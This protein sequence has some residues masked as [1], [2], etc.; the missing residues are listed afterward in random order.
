MSV[1]SNAEEQISVKQKS[2]DSTS[3]DLTSPALKPLNSTP[4]TAQFETISCAHP[5]KKPTLNTWWMWRT[6]TQVELK[7]ENAQNSEF[8]TWENGSVNYRFLMHAEKKV[9]EYSPVDLK[10]LNIAADSS[11][12][13]KVSNLVLQ[14]DLASM[15]K[16]ALKKTYNGLALNR[17]D[18][19]IEGV[20][21]DIIWIEQLQIPLQMTYSYPKHKTTINLLDANATSATKSATSEQMLNSYER[22]D[23]ADIGDMEHSASAKKW[24]SK[25]QDAPGFHSHH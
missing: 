19:K 4:L 22:I 15:K 7:K 16:T 13:Q 1:A 3:S 24:L 5:C 14:K 25:A 20:N 11:K 8:W 6:A 10:M 17:Y 23:F 2:P 18:G 21:A 12:W 9:I